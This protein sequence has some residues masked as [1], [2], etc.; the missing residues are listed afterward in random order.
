MSFKILI[1][2]DKI[3]S[4]DL[5][6]LFFTTKGYQVV[7]ASDGNEGLN[8]TQTE[9]PDLI[10]TDL[11]MPNGNGVDMI[12]Q[13]RSEAQIAHIPIGVYTAYGRGFIESAMDAGA[14]EVFTKPVN[15]E[16]LAQFAEG[17]LGTPTQDA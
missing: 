4:R 6:Q 15:L 8:I 12:K 11:T 10:I 3:D 5:L 14:N 7:T 9:K 17:F 13:I 16:K 2:E 1:V